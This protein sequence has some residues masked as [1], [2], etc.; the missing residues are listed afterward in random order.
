LN[1]LKGRGTKGDCLVE[2]DDP[3][4]KERDLYLIYISAYLHITYRYVGIIAVIAEA[5][6]RIE[7]PWRGSARR[8]V[9]VSAS[10]W[11][12][13]STVPALQRAS[14]IVLIRYLR[15]LV[16]NYLG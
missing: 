12:I 6:W 1:T 4:S 15:F 10:N 3:E 11:H 9:Y 14:S 8:L 7:L 13:R 2:L 5:D 16:V